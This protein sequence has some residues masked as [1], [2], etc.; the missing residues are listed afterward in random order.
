ML[1]KWMIRIAA[2]ISFLCVVIIATSLIVALSPTVRAHIARAIVDWKS[3]SVQLS[4]LAYRESSLT[5][6]TYARGNCGAC[7]TSAE[8]LRELVETVRRLPYVTT[9]L[10]TPRAAEEE[11]DY[12][13]AIGLNKSAIVAANRQEMEPVRAVPSIIV[14]NRSGRILYMHSGSITAPPN[15][16]DYLS[17]VRK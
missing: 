10:V 15:L 9:R 14:I 17:P 1:N 8:A 5:V 7:V 12:A 13:D 6:L 2:A 16:T 11:E 4:R 3:R